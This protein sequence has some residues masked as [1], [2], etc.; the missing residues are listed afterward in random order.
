LGDNSASLKAHP[1]RDCDGGNSIWHGGFGLGA[2][3]LRLR[4]QLA[5]VSEGM[6]GRDGKFGTVAGPHVIEG[7][8]QMTVITSEGLTLPE[9]AIREDACKDPGPVAR[10]AK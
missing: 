10:E 7:A 8:K 3:L 6:G 5:S 9:R 2:V 4:S 1:N